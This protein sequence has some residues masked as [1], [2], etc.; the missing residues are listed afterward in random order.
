M[1]VLFNWDANAGTYQTSE[2]FLI[3]WKLKEFFIA[4]IQQNSEGGNIKT[5]LVEMMQAQ[6][7]VAMSEVS[8]G[9]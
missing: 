2:L 4:Q 9:Q 3:I 5:E 1:I 8:M 7:L 6:I